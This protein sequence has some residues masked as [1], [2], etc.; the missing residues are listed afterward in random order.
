MELRQSHFENAH[1][2][3]GT[4]DE[5]IPVYRSGRVA[6]DYDMMHPLDGGDLRH[7]GESR[8]IPPEFLDCSVVLLPL[9]A[10]Q[11][12]AT[13]FD[14]TQDLYNGTDGR[15]TPTNTFDDDWSQY[16]DLFEL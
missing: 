7:E 9:D 13:A 8:S 15:S 10:E 5:F 14:D 11:S 4:G 6:P 3:W 12:S 2:P 16:V 1:L